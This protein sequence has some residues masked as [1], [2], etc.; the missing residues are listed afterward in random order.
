MLN[1]K[2]II[3]DDAI[4][5][6]EQSQICELWRK[7]LWAK[8]ESY[9]NHYKHSILTVGTDDFI[10]SHLILANKLPGGKL[11][12]VMMYKAVRLSKYKQ[13]SLP[14]G[15]NKT[16]KGT[17]LENSIILNKILKSGD[18]VS[19]NSSFTVNPKYQNHPARSSFKDYIS[20]L[21]YHYNIVFNV[22]Q[23]VSIAAIKYKVDKYFL[24]LGA[25]P[26]HDAFSVKASDMEPVQLFHH[27]DTNI[28]PDHILK[29]IKKY[30]H[31]S[32]S[33]K[34]YHSNDEDIKYK[35]VA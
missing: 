17:H 18:E 2:L 14:F 20:I 35:I 24:S 8:V 4:H 28:V 1:L 31:I 15:L 13:F 7:C 22:K 12:P 21:L 26:I 5:L 11:D 3:I 10:G 23:W 32:D 34:I 19:Y 6:R 30:K 16:L 9:E 27:S 25:K 29:T 33:L